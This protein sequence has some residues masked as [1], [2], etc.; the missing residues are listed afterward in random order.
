MI[1]S[2]GQ[3]LL[4]KFAPYSTEAADLLGS[5]GNA[6]TGAGII[7]ALAPIHQ[8]FK[9]NAPSSITSGE[10]STLTGAGFA[11]GVVM[12]PELAL[13]FGVASAAYIAYGWVDSDSN[14]TLSNAF[15]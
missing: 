14:N 9:D 10:I 3:Q 11:A 1:A 7:V 4:Q 2:S 12:M 13:A 5:A 6:A 15:S 8:A